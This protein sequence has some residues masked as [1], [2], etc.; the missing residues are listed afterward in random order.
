MRTL[1]D[2]LFESGVFTNNFNSPI[3]PE[4]SDI[5]Y[6]AIDGLRGAS[7]VVVA[8]NKK[9]TASWIKFKNNVKKMDALLPEKDHNFTRKYGP[10]ILGLLRFLYEGF[11][12][13][14]N[15]NNPGWLIEINKGR[16]DIGLYTDD[17]KFND[18]EFEVGFV[19]NPK[20]N[21]LEVTNEGTNKT[22]AGKMKDLCDEYING[23]LSYDKIQAGLL[24]KIEAYKKKWPKGCWKYDSNLHNGKL[25][26]GPIKLDE[27]EWELVKNVYKKSGGWHDDL[28]IRNGGDWFQVYDSDCGLINT[29]E[30]DRVIHTT[31]FLINPYTKDTTLG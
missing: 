13:L 10:G 15:I 17:K 8:A 21:T 30:D 28:W 22:L 29:P 7:Y 26:P 5:G 19:F 3:K 6:T 2:F 18:R 14:T 16:I 11:E 1:K 24:K 27:A 31:A 23:D 9:I 12:K 4:D 20:T 25:A